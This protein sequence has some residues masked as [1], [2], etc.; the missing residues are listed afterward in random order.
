[1]SD[2]RKLRLRRAGAA[3]V[4]AVRK[5]S[6][7]A[8]EKWVPL[9]NREPLPMTADY[10]KAVIAHMI[11]LHEEDGALVALV[12]TVAMDEHLLIENIAVH[13]DH[14]GKGLGDALLAHAESL[15][16]TLNFAE[17]RLYTNE[18]FTSNIAFYERR[19]YSIFSREPI[20]AGGHLVR[21]RKSLPRPVGT[22]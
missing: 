5:L 15:A 8:Y 18:A 4:A 17:A 6:R 14:Q 22:S 21:M 2:G 20:P 3:D 19:G 7:L 11:D 1:V 9:I 10:E 16:G 12:E 13:P